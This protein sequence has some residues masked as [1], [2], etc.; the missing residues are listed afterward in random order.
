MPDAV[1]GDLAGGGP[2]ET[3]AEH[4]RPRVP[5]RPR[6]GDGDDTTPTPTT[7]AMATATVALPPMAPGAPAFPVTE[8]TAPVGGLTLSAP[9]MVTPWLTVTER[10]AEDERDGPGVA[11][12]T[13][14]PPPHVPLRPG[15]AN[16]VLSDRRTGRAPGRTGRH[17][18]L[19]PARRARSDPPRRV[20]LLA[21]PAEG[22]PQ[23]L[24]TRVGATLRIS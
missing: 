16:G 2:G 8:N 24:G 1:A 23:L 13:L 22:G 7:L 19:S 18:R 6:V 9:E 5:V 10:A 3:A 17:R 15:T 4:K 21:Q 14:Q 11:A 12:G 20:H